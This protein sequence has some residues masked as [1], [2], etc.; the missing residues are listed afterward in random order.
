MTKE[1]AIMSEGRGKYSSTPLNGL[2]HSRGG[3]RTPPE[4]PRGNGQGSPFVFLQ[5]IMSAVLPVLF[6]VALILGY[7][8]LHWIF[9]ALSAVSLLLMWGTR[10]FVSQART[11]MT[12]IYTALMIVS[13]GAALWFT[14]PM[15]NRN[16][17]PAQPQGNDLATIFGRDVTARDVQDFTSQQNVSSTET[18][19]PTASA[20]SEA[21]R[22]LENFMNSWMS[23][24]YNAMLSY[25]VPSW[26]NAQENPQHAIFKIR[27]TSTPT[28]YE[29]ISASGTEADDS[30][31]LTMIASIDK[32][33]GKAPQPYRYEVLMLRVNGIWYVDPASL[34][35]AAE[36]REEVTPTV[37][38]TLMPTY[39][40]DANT[41]LYY[42]PEGGTYYHKNENCSKVAIKYLPLKGSF[43][44]KEITSPAY[45]SLVPCDKCNPPNRPN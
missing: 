21:Q 18:P 42:N 7:T 40:V 1:A 31:T 25:C 39:T 5:V 28:T 22:Q 37:Q 33:T 13:L 6:I 15:I 3:Y 29:I 16:P 8:E 10:A 4:R 30:R 14:H 26:V 36:I 44:Y 17:E 43:L 27:G 32:G 41:R 12:L 24:D 11:T 35:S 9:L 23:L 20:Q 19:V 34:S 45:A 2:K 38:I